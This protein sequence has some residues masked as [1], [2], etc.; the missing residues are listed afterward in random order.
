LRAQARDQRIDDGRVGGELAR[1][2]V[3]GFG[4][5]GAQNGPRP[6]GPGA[7]QGQ[8]RGFGQGFAPPGGT[9]NGG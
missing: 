7:G 4:G 3:G 9:T 6:F 5:F 2:G 1:D 8:P